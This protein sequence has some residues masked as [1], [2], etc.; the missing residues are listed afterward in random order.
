V[1]Q[2]RLHLARQREPF[3]DVQT[4][5]AN[6]MRGDGD[7]PV[8]PHQLFALETDRFNDALQ[9]QPE[10]QV[11]ELDAAAERMRAKGLF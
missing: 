5:M 2:F 1:W 4:Q 11:E 6:L 3:R 10:T 8:H 7:E 9:Q